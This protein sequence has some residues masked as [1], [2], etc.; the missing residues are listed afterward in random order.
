MNIFIDM[1]NP[2]IFEWDHYLSLVFDPWLHVSLACGAYHGEISSLHG[3]QAIFR[4]TVVRQTMDPI[5]RSKWHLIY[6]FDLW[7]MPST[8]Y[9]EINKS[10]INCDKLYENNLL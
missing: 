9:C 10:C 4:S 2:T 3:F 5:Y 6:L 1:C 8:N 7:I